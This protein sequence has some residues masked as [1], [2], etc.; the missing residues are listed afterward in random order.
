M[1]EINTTN[2]SV[3]A[4]QAT[5]FNEAYQRHLPEFQAVAID[6]LV[7]V[8]V[9]IATVVTTVL[10]S[11]PEILALAPGI[12]EQLPKFDLARVRDL[13]SYAMALS[14][15]NT[16]YLLA[17]Q[18]PDSRQ[19][20]LDEGSKLRETLLGDANALIQRGMLNG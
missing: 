6:E 3:V 12:S 1:P 11:L 15:A 14:H 17:T 13:E 18:P 7:T 19:A 16:L 20:L 8:N 4:E 10:G 5:P 9:D 2:S